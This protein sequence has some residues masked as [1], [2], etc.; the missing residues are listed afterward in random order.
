MTNKKT[1]ELKFWITVLLSLTTTQFAIA[2]IRFL[3]S[4][5]K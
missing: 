2:G 4:S 1:N 5:T 3:I